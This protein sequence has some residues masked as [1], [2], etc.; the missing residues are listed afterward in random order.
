MQER[1]KALMQPLIDERWARGMIVGVLQDGQ[2]DYFR[3]GTVGVQSRRRPDKNT[4]FEIG[5]ITKVFTSLLLA[6]MTV[7]EEIGLDDELR[8][9]LPKELKLPDPGGKP[10]TLR[11]LA[12]HASG[13][14]NIPLNFWEPVDNRYDSNTGGKRWGVYSRNKLQRYLDRPFPP[15]DNSRPYAYSTLDG[16]AGIRI[17][18]KGR[19]FTRGAVSRICQPLGMTRSA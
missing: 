7:K 14:P 4:V 10:I 18:A 17:G 8:K 9:Y 6:E 16:L 3:F 15:I 11:D 19:S 12:T 13:L 1:V 5:S 2:K